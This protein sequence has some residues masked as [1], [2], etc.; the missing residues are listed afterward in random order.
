MS[1]PILYTSV[2]VVALCFLLAAL[3]PLR[4]LNRRL[5]GPDPQLQLVLKAVRGGAWQPAADLM[6]AAGTDWERRTHYA[7]HL[8]YSAA[9]DGDG[10]LRAWQAAAPDDPDAFLIA[11]CARVRRAWRLRGGR[12]ASATSQQQFA[13]FHQE[14]AAARGELAQAARLCPKD[15]MPHAEMISVALGLGCRKGD[16]DAL[17]AEVEARSPHHF[18]AHAAA[19]QYFC[20]KWR[21]S[22]AEVEE[23]AAR[24]ARQAPRGS[25]L[26]TLPLFA[27]YE[28]VDLKGDAAGLFGTPQVIA[29]VDAALEDVA[30][31]DDHPYLAHARHLLA[32][33]LVRQRR[34]RAALEQFRQ[35]DGYVDAIPWRYSPWGK[36][37]YRS[38]RSRAVWGALLARR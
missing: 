29:L 14:L 35:V 36:I 23:F 11:A 18:G 4:P 13:G 30:A 31:A 28:E 7:R 22:R 34:Y 1:I 15:P 16:M 17:W 9:Y 24:A 10:W 38:H 8:A 12:V 21:G 33:F 19:L 20:S 27:W 25:L 26:A 2:V 37:S 3:I 6:K 32:Y 5:A